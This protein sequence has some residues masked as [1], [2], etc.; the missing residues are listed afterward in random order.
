M[1]R[2]EY[3]V[4]GLALW[5]ATGLLGLSISVVRRE[6]RKLGQGVASLI[7]VWV[8]YLAALLF[9]SSREPEQHVAPGRPACFHAMCLTVARVEEVP[10]YFG[11]NRVGDGSR[12]L[13]VTVRV[14]NH[15]QSSAEEKT[16][17]YL[18]DGQHH[19]WIETP[20][21]SGNRLDGPVAAGGSVD[22][23]PVFQVAPDATNLGLVLTHGRSSW[24][25]LVIGDPESLA[26][27]PRVLDLGR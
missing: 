18:R 4:L 19:V 20:G 5:T 21:L 16:G 24:H 27:R 11:R 26:H 15:G 23:E 2:W 1:N 8:I 22:S 13:R 7:G 10:G 12:L 25:R 9:V 6:R 14:T 3:L 17:A